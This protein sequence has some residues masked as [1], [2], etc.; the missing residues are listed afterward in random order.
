MP[1][2]AEVDSEQDWLLGS[3]E[4]LLSSLEDRVYNALIPLLNSVTADNDAVTA[5][6]SQL[7]KDFADVRAMDVGQTRDITTIAKKIEYFKDHLLQAMNNDFDVFEDAVEV[8][9]QFLESAK[10]T[11]RRR[12]CE[13]GQVTLTGGD[14]EFEYQFQTWFDVVPGIVWGVCGFDFD[15]NQRETILGYDHQPKHE[16]NAA[17]FKINAY[18]TKTG[19]HLKALDFSF[20]DSES[21]S[22]DVCFKACSIG[23]SPYV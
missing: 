3:L 18:A 7:L 23:A 14:E 12:M 4:G 21:R 10:T 22:V 5:Q 19:I 20:G 6:Q 13:V 8:A 15:L 16:V 17:G 9:A 1:G 2:L 11:E